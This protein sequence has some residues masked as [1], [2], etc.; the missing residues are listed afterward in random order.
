MVRSI[1]AVVVGF[2]YIG[3]L[4]FGTDA[5]IRSRVPG[6][7]AAAGRTDSVPLL[8]AT[9]AYVALFAISGCYLAARLAP[10]RPMRHAL[11]LGVLGLAFNVMGT[12]VAWG[13]A[14]AWY[15]V[16]SLV[17]VMPYAYLG[18]RLRERQ[19][20]HAPAAMRPALG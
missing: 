9:L 11:I 16:V 12:V 18:G 15:H 17:L 8:L 7:F 5:V 6:A 4:S 2:F 19:Q 13:T 20:E 14:P 3:L 1:V 10:S